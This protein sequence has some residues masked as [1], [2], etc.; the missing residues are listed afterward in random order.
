MKYKRQTI[1]ES[2]R[3]YFNYWRFNENYKY[4]MLCYSEL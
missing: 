4:L 2:F 1:Y 3:D